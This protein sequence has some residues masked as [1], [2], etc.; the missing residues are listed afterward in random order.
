MPDSP[1]Y[2]TME[3][4]HDTSRPPRRLGWREYALYALAYFIGAE[5]GH[6]LSFGE[7]TFAIFWPAYGIFIA[8]LLLTD[9]RDWPGVIAA[10]VVAN[11]A[12]DVGLHGRSL[13]CEL[14][15]S[16]ANVC[17]AVLAALLTQRLVGTPISFSTI[18]RYLLF[19]VTAGC[20]GPVVGA[21][22]G[23]SVAY[24][25][26]AQ[27]GETWSPQ[28]WVLWLTS[29]AFGVLTFGALIIAWFCER[30][31]IRR[32]CQVATWEAAL[33]FL[34]VAV[35]AVIGFSWPP[36]REQLPVQYPMLVCPALVWAGLRLGRRGALVA[37]M[38]TSLI[39]I[40]MTAH[41]YG[42]YAHYGPTLFEQVT[43]MQL[44]ILQVQIL[45][46]V[47]AIIVDETRRAEGLS[48]SQYKLLSGVLEGV[49]DGI[50]LKDREGRFHV[51]NPAAAALYQTTVEEMI[52]KTDADFLAP[53]V[54]EKIYEDDRRSIDEERPLLREERWDSPQGDMFFLT[55][56]SP[57]R[58]ESG[59]VAGVIGI[60]RNITHLRHTSAAL[61]ISEGRFRTLANTGALGVFETDATGKC[62]YLN[63]R[64]CEMTGLEPE[65]GLGD[66]WLTAVHPEDVERVASYWQD[67]V[68]RA[69]DEI[70]QEFR[71]ARPD[72][73][74]VWVHTFASAIRDERGAVRGFIGAC[75]DVTARREAEQSLR[76][77]NE[78]LEQRVAE[79]T[80][81]L[82]AM[83]AQL[84][85][86]M[87]A[88][89]CVQEK[90]HDQ[91]LQLAH[92][93]RVSMMGEMAASLAH[94]LNQPLYAIRN[95][96]SG[97]Q[98]RL[99]GTDLPPFLS[100]ALGE[101]S[102]ETDRAAEIIRRTRQFV[103]VGRPHMSPVD[104]NAVV[105]DALALVEFE[106]KRR[107]M[108]VV[109]KPAEGLPLC[110]ADSVALQ[111]VIVNLI[112]NAFDAMEPEPRSDRTV[113]LEITS[114]Q[115]RVGLCCH[116]TGS[117]ILPEN[118]PR[119]FQAFFTTKAEGL[120]MGLAISRS[121]IEAHGGELTHRPREGG[122]TTF[123]CFLPGLNEKEYRE[124]S[125]AHAGTASAV[126]SA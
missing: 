121:I 52:G 125:L 114:D 46:L 8:V 45:P 9:R 77:A 110:L 78:R 97:L 36:D 33:V 63:P 59:Q 65:D 89:K 44:F 51:V 103:G 18:G 124:G 76:E 14:G 37:A 7:P 17:E 107:S 53:E 72:A 32:D 79:R 15:Y 66:G 87:A 54:A 27:P 10:S 56:R 57:F 31:V 28:Q 22:I 70:T 116:D 69:S 12:S 19:V 61:I 62:I 92:V 43:A 119:I 38:I 73:S 105:E 20:V 104:L 29:D 75:L 26:L 68:A 109:F 81:E 108:Q 90:L 115:G 112:R 41:G 30:P 64:W 111:Q 117:G 102:R 4:V 99:A 21:T 39:S 96:L 67:Q 50:V 122:G 34:V 94:E 100:D 42:L 24:L 58:D 5:L 1:R 3:V 55:T 16:L 86:E 2:L 74:T 6:L 88:R 95:Y 71:F 93:S 80:R 48:D 85:E 60:V 98:R 91:Q 35:S 13:L 82:Q 123:C 49:D 11:F 40:A 101:V 84:H 83:N 113:V 25:V 106:A 23:A 126:T 118:T 120:G 47:L